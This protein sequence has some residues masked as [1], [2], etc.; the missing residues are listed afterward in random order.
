MAHSIRKAW[1]SKTPQGFAY[2]SDGNLTSDDRW[3]YAWDGENR[4]VSM[5]T[6]PAI[7]PPVGTFPLSETRKME[8]AYDMQGRLSYAYLWT[9]A[10]GAQYA[11]RR[12]GAFLRRSAVSDHLT[13]HR[14]SPAF[15]H[16]AMLTFSI[17]NPGTF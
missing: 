15:S 8:F 13:R 4:L 1:L 11:C 16:R 12:Q 7:L 14:N 6:N 17:V 9:F 5:H 3:I 2:D 10:D